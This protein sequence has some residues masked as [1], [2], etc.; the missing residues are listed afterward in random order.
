MLQASSSAL[1]A[2]AAQL[3]KAQE[4]HQKE[5]R[6]AREQT[7]RV[8]EEQVMSGRVPLTAIDGH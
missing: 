6:A 7:R 8:V 3:D 4:S 2:K 1:K 5:L